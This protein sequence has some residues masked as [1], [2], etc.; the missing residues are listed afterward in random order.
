MNDASKI[1]LVANIIESA[2]SIG[3]HSTHPQAHSSALT[4]LEGQVERLLIVLLGREPTQE[5]MNRTLRK[6][7]T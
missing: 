7:W 4:D 1:A 5:E 3:E 6:I 2:H